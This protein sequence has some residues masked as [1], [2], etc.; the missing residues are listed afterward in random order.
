MSLFVN[1]NNISQIEINLKKY[2]K[3]L[4]DEMKLELIE[5]INKSKNHI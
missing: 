1:N 2:I 3:E 5:Q 4:L